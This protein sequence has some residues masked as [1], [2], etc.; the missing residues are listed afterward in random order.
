M[1]VVQMGRMRTAPP[2]HW[3]C[4]ISRRT[5]TLHVTP[6]FHKPFFGIP[7]LHL[8]IYR[9][10]VITA[11]ANEAASSSSALRPGITPLLVQ[12]FLVEA[13]YFLIRL[14]PSATHI[15]RSPIF[16]VSVSSLL[17][18]FLSD[19]LLPLVPR[20]DPFSK[21]PCPRPTT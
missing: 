21:T 14:F 4:Q 12:V 17:C 1:R 11:A 13:P 18:S 2:L 7:A 10:L 5:N 15:F 19:C 8:I 9:G 3:Y 16:Y 6:Y 20:L